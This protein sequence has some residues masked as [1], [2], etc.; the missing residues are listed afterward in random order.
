MEITLRDYQGPEDLRLQYDFW[1]K[2]TAGLPWAWKPTTSPSI[3]HEQREFDPRTRCFA[4]EG[5]RLV[6]YM[7]FTGSGDFVSLG[8]PWVLES[9]EGELQER[10]FERVYGFAA[11]PS[12][13]GKTFAQR[14]RLQ[15]DKQ[16]D[17]FEEKDLK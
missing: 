7:G 4:F 16:I 14:F 9:Y 10:L 3:F 15:W 5:D 2:V 6:G 11:S 1:E 17:F 12:Y 13:G 8:Y